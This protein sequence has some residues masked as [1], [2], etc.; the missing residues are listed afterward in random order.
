MG[1]FIIIPFKL[2]INGCLACL[3]R[4]L[5]TKFKIHFFVFFWEADRNRAPIH[6]CLTLQMPT[7]SGLAGGG[8]A[9]RPALVQGVPG[10]AW[11][12]SWCFLIWS[13]II[14]YGCHCG[15]RLQ[16]CCDVWCFLCGTSWCLFLLWLSVMNVITIEDYK[17]TYWPKLDGAIDQLLT[18]S[19]GDYIPISYEQIYR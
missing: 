9:H 4:W 14:R 10:S 3:T 8:S 19:P 18:Q 13:G 16:E 15:V 5:F 11:V 7:L 1:R 2:T 12:G 17:S 6:P